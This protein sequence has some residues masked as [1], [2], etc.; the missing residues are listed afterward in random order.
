MTTIS[1]EL[2]EVLNDLVKINNDRIEGYKTAAEEIKGEDFSLQPVFNRLANESR[3]NV[4][5]LS[6]H[7]TEMG[8]EVEDD[9]TSIGKLYRAWM[10]VKATFT[11]NGKTSILESCEFGEDQAQKAYEEALSNAELD[12]ETRALVSSQKM[13]LKEGHDLI[14]QLRDTNK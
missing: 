9:T 3:R 1:K 2:I 4:S 14:K 10:D 11:G 5:Q 6:M 7:I 13:A 12:S 8:G